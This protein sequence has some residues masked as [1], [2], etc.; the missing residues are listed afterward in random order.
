MA[1]SS[2]S[3]VVGFDTERGRLATTFNGSFQTIGSA[4]SVNPYIIIFDNQSDV[5]VPISVDGVNIWKT[6]AP[7]QS[8]VLDLR[9]NHG[10]AQNYTIAVGTQFTTN[11]SVGTTGSMLISINFGA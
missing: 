1:N 9:A 5:P 11:A 7:Y 4:L 6:F 3:M 8:L 2:S 10:I